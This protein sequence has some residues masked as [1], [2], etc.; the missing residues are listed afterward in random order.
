VLVIRI[1]ATESNDSRNGIEDKKMISTDPAVT[2]DPCIMWFVSSGAKDSG[3]PVGGQ[4][5]VDKSAGGRRI[6]IVE[7]EILVA[8]DTRGM[9]ESQGYVVVGIAVS[10]E[11]ALNAAARERPD[12]ILMD[13]R[14]EGSGDGIEVAKKIR[15][16]FGI[17][18]LFITANEDATTRERA[19]AAKPLG[20]L[21]KPINEDKLLR[22][23]NALGD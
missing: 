21:A 20:F 12:L 8:L 1:N 19:A 17:P 10:A 14:L 11:Q 13:I 23:L 18:S 3:Q 2:I 6:L 16:N 15:A 4:K 22:A 5:S 7:D 9:L